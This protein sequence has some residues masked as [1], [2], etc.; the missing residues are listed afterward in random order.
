MRSLK[1]VIRWRPYCHYLKSIEIV[2]FIILYLVWYI[3]IIN[4]I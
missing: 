4:V 3:A 2:S 1:V